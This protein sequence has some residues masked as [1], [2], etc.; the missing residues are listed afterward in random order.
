MSL[1]SIY[2][3]KIASDA[4][5]PDPQQQSLVTELDRFSCALHSFASTSFFHRLRKGDQHPGHLYLWGEVGRG[6]TMLMDMLYQEARVA[7]RRVHFGSFMR[8]LHM[9][10][11]EYSGKKNPLDMIA[12]RTADGL[13]LLCFDEFQVIDIGDAMLLATF[14]TRLLRAP[15]A[16]CMTSNLPPSE[17]YNNGLQRSRFLP[18][19]ALLEQE[20]KVLSLQSKQDYRRL[21][22]TQAEHYFFPVTTS[23]SNQ[24]FD[25]FKRFVHQAKPSTTTVNGR[26]IQ[27]LGI[28][29]DAVC[30]DF[31]ALCRQARSSADYVAISAEFPV[32]FLANIEALHD[33]Q[34]SDAVRRFINLI[35]QLYDNAVFL[36]CLATID[37]DDIYTGTVL[38][39]PF[40]RCHSRLIEMQSKQYL[41]DSIG[42]RK[43]RNFN[44][45]PV[46]S[47]EGY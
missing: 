25:A 3:Q 2:Q 21:H 15:V 13:S 11:N 18:T 19:I 22:M 47:L 31:D 8:W 5:L 10:L 46:A 16:L 45:P 26:S 12:D 41:E 34:D 4:L 29:S 24:F 44:P 32:V 6:K 38:A 37:I 14:F 1:N 30:F 39:Q 9:E 42:R 28:G 27:V 36:V 7:K 43:T 23:T 20:F 35:D 17:L 40:E 33:P